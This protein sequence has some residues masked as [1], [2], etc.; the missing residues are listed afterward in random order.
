AAPATTPSET[1]SDVTSPATGELT[2]VAFAPTAPLPAYWP[3]YYIADPLGFYEDEGIDIE[4]ENV[5]TAVQQSLLSGRLTFAGTG[6]DY[7][8]QAPTLDDPPK[9]F[10]NVDRYLWVMVTLADSDFDTAADLEGGR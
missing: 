7:I 4:F 1:T 6:L 2:T 3:Y 10:M 5:Q 8:P 9:W